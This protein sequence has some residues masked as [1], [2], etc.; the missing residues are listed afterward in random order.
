M[1]SLLNHIN[2]N[3]SIIEESVNA[4]LGEQINNF[5]SILISSGQLSMISKTHFPK[6]LAK[7]GVLFSRANDSIILKDLF[8]PKHSIK[9]ATD[10]MKSFDSST[11]N[12]STVSPRIFNFRDPA[13]NAFTI[14]GVYSEMD[15]SQL[16]IGGVFS[17]GLH[18]PKLKV[19]L[20]TNNKPII[21]NNSGKSIHPFIFQ[22]SGFSRM[23]IPTSQRHAIM[24]HELGHWQDKTGTTGLVSRIISPLITMRV[25]LSIVT[26]GVSLI[27]GLLLMM[28]TTYFSRRAEF[29]AD[30]FA[31]NAGL[32]KDLVN[33][34]R[35]LERLDS[36]KSKEDLSKISTLSDKFTVFTDIISTHP[37]IYRR[38]KRLLE[39]SS[40][41]T[42]A[43]DGQTVTPSMIKSLTSKLDTIIADQDFIPE[44]AIFSGK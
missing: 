6:A 25:F 30:L 31:K 22:T 37:S 21:T 7:Y 15:I 32:G 1:H 13:L 18:V 11:S 43:N 17:K 9:P 42:E 4:R 36:I 24:M 27:I 34:L 23:K 29:D 2:Y 5:I 14:P 20:D 35:A 38:S 16:T 8:G 33:A 3:T 12:R 40:S 19:S 10:T 26:F 28:M 44:L 41:T 39:I